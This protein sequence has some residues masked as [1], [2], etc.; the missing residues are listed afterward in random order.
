ML[1]NQQVMLGCLPII[2]FLVFYKNQSSFLQKQWDKLF[3][4]FVF[5]IILLSIVQL[6]N[7]YTNK[8]GLFMGFFLD[9][10]PMLGFFYSKK[11]TLEDFAKLV[12]SVALFHLLLG[13]LLYPPFQ[14]NIIPQEISTILTEGLPFGRMASVSG[15]LGFGTLMM[16]SGICAY[17]YN[18]L[19]YP[20]L[21]LG[22]LF[23]AQRSAWLASFYL[24]LLLGFVELKEGKIIKTLKLSF[25]FLFVI[26]FVM[27]I[28]SYFK[29]DMSFI[30]SRF[31]SIESAGSDRHEQWMCGLFNFGTIPI[32]TGVGQVGQV[33]GR[34][35]QSIYEIVVDGD[36]FRSLSEYGFAAIMFYI[37]SILVYIY[38][39]LKN[40]LNHEGLCVFTILGGILIQMI[41][42][43]VSEFYFN[44]FLVWC[45]WGYFYQYLNNNLKIRT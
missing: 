16:I 9:I 23:S 6:V 18:K 37:I 1:G 13:I 29:I 32:G 33:A 43:N 20:F 2:Y 22:V 17:Y 15:S 14:L 42:S 12:S 25:S 44:N 21:I 40:R 38:S 24:F 3:L 31:D 11:C 45:V 5:Y 8:L 30:S 28:V 4:Y 27:S 26:L 39:L 34:Y 35:E 10:I 41:G 19:L 7:P 36:Y